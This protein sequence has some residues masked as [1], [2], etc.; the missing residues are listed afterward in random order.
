[1]AQQL[2]EILNYFLE[3]YIPGKN[4]IFGKD[5]LIYNSICDV[6]PQK[7][8]ETQLVDSKEYKVVGSVGQGN[9]AKVPW[10]AIFRKDITLSAQ[11]GV[12]IVYLLSSDGNSLYL[13]LNQGVTEAGKNSTASET[14]RALRE[15][16]ARISAQLNNRSFLSDE[17]INLG[18]DIT[19]LGRKYQKGTIFYKK[20]SK[21]NIPSEE[22]LQDD[23]KNML[24]IY[25][26]YYDKVYKGN[27]TPSPEPSPAV[28]EV[29][30]TKQKIFFGAPGT[31]KS[32][33]VNSLLPNEDIWSV[34]SEIRK[35]LFL[36]SDTAKKA[37]YAA[38]LDNNE[39]FGDIWN[40]NDLSILEGKLSEVNSV[41]NVSNPEH[42]AL[43]AYIK[44][45]KEYKYERVFR[46]TFHPDY[47]YAQ[48]VGA[49]K[50]KKDGSAIT[51]S[52]VPQVFAKAYAAAWKQ[53]FAAGNVS[54]ADNQVYLVIEEINRGN[55]AQIFGDIF[56]LLDRDGEGFS[57]YSI[58]ADCD[59]AEWLK[60]DSILKIVWSEYET[61]VGDGKL[62]LPPNLNILATMNTSDQ[63][64]FPMDSAFKRRFDWEYVPIKYAKDS[65]C[66]DDWKADEFKIVIGDSMYM[67]L[68]FL[69]KVNVDIDE[70]THSEDKQMGEFFIKPKRDDLKISFDE[71]RSKV[72][73]YLWDSVYKDETERQAVFH[74]PY[75]DGD[76]KIKS[77][78]FQ[79]LF[80]KDAEAIVNKIMENL[81]VEK[82]TA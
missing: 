35:Q 75:G 13:T 36:D 39:K 61:K 34:S 55:C 77:V 20:Y 65:D 28:V 44:Y 48:F 23:L 56:Q 66:G 2:T 73:F 10:L 58:D 12:Y 15:N 78:T 45:L 31:G 43:Q 76:D 5:A 17:N 67:W 62:K 68:D 11:N 37:H 29:N 74:F 18:N 79:S 64:L 19:D 80:G 27:S 46:T 8:Y 69:K 82:V 71:F 53:Y 52:F 7:I 4:Q 26:E 47:D 38:V 33:K 6:A 16:A 54:T 72:L 30:M 22:I 41:D 40:V 42:S 1:M 50:P 32:F 25:Q 9:W 63:S 51:Y 59:F 57:Q 24:D 70:T 21:Q 49:Y 14:I 60:E 81:K 3:D